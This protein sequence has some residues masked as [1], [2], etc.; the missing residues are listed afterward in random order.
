MRRRQ[1]SFQVTL[2]A[3]R[4][5]KPLVCALALSASPLIALAQMASIPV[6]AQGAFAD[7]AVWFYK[8]PAGTLRNGPGIKGTDELVSVPPP[9]P[10]SG[11]A[12]VGITLI[13]HAIDFANYPLHIS[14]VDKLF[15]TRA[16]I[17]LYVRTGDETRQYDAGAPAVTERIV[18]G[19]AST[20]FLGIPPIPAA[21]AIPNEFKP[22]FAYAKSV[23][24]RTDLP[25]DQRDLRHY[26]VMFVDAPRTTW[27]ELAPAWAANE[28]PHLGCQ[29]KLGRDM[30]IG[31]EKRRSNVHAAP[32]IRCF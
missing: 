14:L 22:A 6:G 8:T 19:P 21:G 15:A 27:I 18:D 9:R 11:E 32:F 23:L 20:P 1:R 12:P 30:V 10:Q 5:G 17:V 24:S 31:F 16:S 28:T 25:D 13:R 3:L 4:L 2:L 29:T 7:V 26:T